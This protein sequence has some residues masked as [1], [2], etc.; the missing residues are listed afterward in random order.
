VELRTALN[1]VFTITRLRLDNMF[2]VHAER[3]A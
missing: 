3:S 2:A 1:E